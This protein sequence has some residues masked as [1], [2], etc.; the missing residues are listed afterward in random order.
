MIVIVVLPPSSKFWLKTKVRHFASNMYCHAFISWFSALHPPLYLLSP[1]SCSGQHKIIW[2][3]SYPLPCLGMVSPVRPDSNLC[4]TQTWRVP[5]GVQCLHKVVRKT[6]ARGSSSQ[7]NQAPDSR[8]LLY[9]SP[10]LLS[11]SSRDG[12]SRTPRG[13]PIAFHRRPW[14]ICSS[15]HCVRFPQFTHQSMQAHS[16]FTNRPCA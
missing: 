10:D 5:S 16:C 4:P 11:S 12:D 3:V 13:L 2:V 8:L 1:T 15:S 7:L 9:P 6:K 14:P